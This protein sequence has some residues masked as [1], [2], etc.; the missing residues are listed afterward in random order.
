MCVTMVDNLLRSLLVD[1]RAVLVDD[2]LWRK[3]DDLRSLL[4]DDL[5]LLWRRVVHMVVHWLVAGI[6][7]WRTAH[8]LKERLKKVLAIESHIDSK[9]Q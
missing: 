1:F 2:L 7:R 3:M 8:R 6:W 5:L 4:V 9:T